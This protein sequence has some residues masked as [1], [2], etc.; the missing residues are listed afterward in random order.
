MK[1]LVGSTIRVLASSGVGI[2]VLFGSATAQTTGD[3]WRMDGYN[4][5]RTSNSTSVGPQV[6]PTADVVANEIVGSI[7]R[8][9][10]SGLLVVGG[11]N[12]VRAYDSDGILRWSASVFGVT[13]VAIGLDERA[14]YATNATTLFSFDV[15]T[16][17][18]LWSP[19]VANNG[20]ESSSLAIARDGTAVFHTGNSFVGGFGERLAALNRDG[21][22]RWETTL[23]SRGYTR[24]VLSNDE[25]AAYVL[26][27]KS[28]FSGPI[29]D[30]VRLSLATGEVL[31]GTP[32]DPRGDVY[33]FTPSGF[34]LTGD[35]NN[36]LLRFSP[37]LQTCTTV[38]TVP[39]VVGLAGTT[40]NNTFIVYTSTPSGT[41]LAAL[42]PLGNTLWS[43]SSAYKSNAHNTY[44]QLLSIDALG[45]VFAIASDARSVD[46]IRSMDGQV[47]WTHTFEANV[48]GI[49]VGTNAIFVTAGSQLIRL[50]A[51]PQ[52]ICGNE[53]DDDGD[54]EIDEGCAPSPPPAE[55]I[56]GNSLDDD[57]DGF[58]DEG[59]VPPPPPAE[60]ICGNGHDD[61]LDGHVDEECPPEQPLI[62]TLNLVVPPLGKHKKLD[63][64]RVWSGF[65]RVVRWQ[66]E[67]QNLPF[68]DNC[69]VDTVAPALPQIAGSEFAE[70]VIRTLAREIA[71]TSL[72][73]ITTGSIAGD[74][75]VRFVANH[76]S[77]LLIDPEALPK[78]PL[79]SLIETSVGFMLPKLVGEYASEILE[80]PT[81][82]ALNELVHEIE[83]DL[84]DEVVV[85]HES[86]S[87][88]QG[89]WLRVRLIYSHTSGYTFAFIA[90]SCGGSEG[91]YLMRYQNDAKG[92]PVDVARVVARRF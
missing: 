49:V 16:G 78:V 22:V 55:E 73:I 3:G 76:L 91:L 70:A 24:V 28:T 87:L 25:T 42:D 85:V 43:S 50:S 72:S 86:R 77:A 90:A 18:P 45:T 14:V 5:Q 54:G 81:S 26:Q 53:I 79:K 1:R 84:R 12:M 9:T 37:D 11:Q 13:D 32:C 51:P 19:Y 21:L 80:G 44:L 10:S 89:G 40:A 83:K 59:C 57:G 52:E 71:E 69:Y 47:L 64:A 35:V 36:D 6:A 48:S 65:N 46:A 61:D 17:A 31:N 33:T 56:C 68:E 4:A 29:G 34:L 88:A 7:R 75:L 39:T 62:D 63:A 67:N 30:V 41:G 38:Q 15:D 27:G 8:S 60:E 66:Y 74:I 20:N 92:L 23:G 2:L 82:F 58:V